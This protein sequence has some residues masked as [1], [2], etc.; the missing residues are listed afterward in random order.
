[1]NSRRTWMLRLTTVLVAVAV[2]GGSLL[3]AE[4]LGTIKS[5]DVDAKKFVVTEKDSE[6]DVDVTINDETV[7]ETAKGKTTGKEADLTK[8]LKKGR[9]VTVTHEGGI[10]S[11]IVIKKGAG[12][13]K[14]EPQ[15]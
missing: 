4:L 12:K 3:A 6:K 7:I 10:A 5:V 1:M 11:K 9:T 14:A 15:N 8:V 13:K 2:A